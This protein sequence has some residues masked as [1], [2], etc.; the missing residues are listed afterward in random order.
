VPGFSTAQ[1]RKKGFPNQGVPVEIREGSPCVEWMKRAV[2]RKNPT[3]KNR[4]CAG[5]PYA[6]KFYAGAGCRFTAFNRDP[7]RD[8]HFS[9][10]F[11]LKIFKRGLLKKFH[12]GDG[13]NILAGVPCFSFDVIVL[14]R[15]QIHTDPINFLAGTPRTSPGDLAM[16]TQ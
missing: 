13:K 15:K 8:E 6:K 3:R 14:L 9:G 7:D 1:I 2:D 5:E 16:G 11:R 12:A 10:R 4:G